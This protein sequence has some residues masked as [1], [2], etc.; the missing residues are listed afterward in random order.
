[1]PQ[2]DIEE[3][4]PTTHVEN[5]DTTSD[6]INTTTNIEA[7]TQL[8]LLS[9]PTV[10][11]STT[12]QHGNVSHTLPPPEDTDQST[13]IANL[14]NT[15]YGH[16]ETEQ[17]IQP[18]PAGGL[19]QIHDDDIGP[20]PPITALESISDSS[21]IAGKKTKGKLEQI[22][23]STAPPLPTKAFDD[24]DIKR[25]IA[26]ETRIDTINDE[27][28]APVPFNVA[29][30]DLEEDAK[31]K[32]WQLNPQSES[33]RDS[34][35]IP[36]DLENDTEVYT[37]VTTPSSLRDRD[38][39]R[40]GGIVGSEEVEE[41]TNSSSLVESGDNNANQSVAMDRARNEM[42]TTLEQGQSDS[43]PIIPEAFLV[44]EESE[45][46]IVYDATPVEPTLP[47]WKR[48]RFVG[49]LL[50]F[51]A[52]VLTIAI[53]VGT[54]FGR[55]SQPT[56][57]GSTIISIESYP[58]ISPAPSTS[59]V[60]SSSPTEC[61]NQIMTSNVQRIDLQNHLLI[62]NPQKV[63]IAVDGT[64]MVVV[65]LDGK[66]CKR[67]CTYSGCKW[68]EEYEGPVFVTFYSLD[69][70]DE[71]QRVSAPFRVDDLGSS[72]SLALSGSTVF[73]G[74]EDANDEAGTVL[75][76]EK[77]LFGEWDRVEDPFIRDTK[78]TRRTTSYHPGLLKQRN[79][80]SYVTIDGDL[81]CVGEYN[82]ND[83]KQWAHLFHRSSDNW[84]QIESFAIGLQIEPF[85]VDFGSV[86]KYCSIAGDIMVVRNSTDEGYHKL[87]LYK[88]D[89][90]LNEAIAIQDPIV[91]GDGYIEEQTFVSDGTNYTQSFIRP[92]PRAAYS[93][94]H[95]FSLVSSLELSKEYLVFRKYY[96]HDGIFIY[97]VD[98]IN[99]TYSKQQQLNITGPS[100][101]SLAIDND[102]L[103]AG[104][105][106][107]TYIYSLQDGDWVES[108]TLAQSFDNYQLSGR[109]I[110]STNSDESKADEIYSFH[111]QD[112][113][114]EAP[115]QTPSVSLAPS[116]SPSLFP[117]MSQ[118]PSILPSSTSSPTVTCY[119]IEVAIDASFQYGTS[120]GLYRVVDGS[121]DKEEVK[122]HLYTAGDKEWSCLQE[123]EYE[124]IIRGSVNPRLGD[125]EFKEGD[126]T[127]TTLDDIKIELQNIVEGGGAVI[128]SCDFY[129]STYFSMPYAIAPSMEPST[130]M[131][132]TLSPPP[133]RK[134]HQ[135]EIGI[136]CDDFPSDISWELHKSVNG[137]GKELVKSQ[138][139]LMGDTSNSTSICLPEGEYQFTIN[140]IF[141]DGIEAPGY[142]NVTSDGNLIV[143]GGE[144]GLGE[145]TSFPIPY[146]P[147]SPTL[148]N[149][150]QEPTTPLPSYPP[151]TPFPTYSPAS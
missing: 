33:G 21:S 80:G 44:E 34:I 149:V 113:I 49:F 53:G 65:A 9:T 105:D 112:C 4:I 6:N 143:Q 101:N 22:E 27:E 46:G 69:N 43:I 106:N 37:T 45:D 133:T 60:P 10:S 97:H 56:D 28:D 95:D 59:L 91:T 104:G 107:E 50:L 144:F 134:C 96:T 92:L 68:C 15:S 18:Q 109:N 67:I 36:T 29:D 103:V 81:A 32:S 126:Y 145:I 86:Y 78:S 62:D 76:Y 48:K 19:L 47:W 111:I 16:N 40:V 39:G 129:D 142:Y 54:Y 3:G 120:W 58:S 137:N 77:N 98:E 151:Q 108:I 23:D 121:D 127:I 148:T 115:T 73:I 117:S 11:T 1:M 119:W 63:K 31:I 79:F 150:T 125:C 24:S 8:P 140:D 87:Q 52:C 72:S 30:L 132:P 138:T 83:K 131:D 41:N 116:T 13:I 51:V 85:E 130:S 7:R 136:V 135:I 88:Y 122:S 38:G 64:N 89:M 84:V 74:F 71:W 75:V 99:Q 123:G 61:V 66:Y 57:S 20:L 141:G 139:A 12:P 25:K 93:G 14:Q 128:G 147:G 2:K 35:A 17:Y 146:T 5:N 102:I 82:W 70:G 55:Q 90:D 118:V 26:L 94:I 100:D 114:Q 110:I 124:F 42:A